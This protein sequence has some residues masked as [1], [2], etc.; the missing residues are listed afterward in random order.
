M[1]VMDDL[2]QWGP[3]SLPTAPRLS[4]AEAQQYC[5]TLA[6]TH[7]ENFP[8]VTWLLP[9]ELRT[10]FYSLYAYCRWSDDLGDE[11]G[12]PARSLELLR[13]WRE[14]LLACYLGETRHPVFI[15]LA[16]TIREYALPAE[17]FLDL[18]SAFEQDQTVR[19]YQTF[20]QLR[21][22]CRRSADPV[23]R[24]ILH[25]GR[26]ATA[27]NIAWSDQICTGLQLA[28]FWQDVRRDW[29]IGRI[30]LPQEDRDRFG[31]TRE[32]LAADVSTEAFRQLLAFEVHRAR[33]WLEGGLPLVGALP[34]RLKF[35]VDLF[36]RGG[37]AILQ[38]IEGLEYRVLEQRPKVTKLDVLQI[39]ASCL[40][41]NT[42]SHWFGTRR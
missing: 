19:E 2:R 21:D 25:L 27:E 38:R 10:P 40:L 23:G 3:D 37:L 28:N 31:V 8:V 20:D 14:E 33:E 36:A 15:A 16:E 39:T 18:I 42:W 22:Y 17:P 26:A 1:S 7:Y 24:L 13:W 9:R 41:R 12:D 4:L 6:T 11:A 34:G 32:M 35:D 30:Y 29:A 5:R